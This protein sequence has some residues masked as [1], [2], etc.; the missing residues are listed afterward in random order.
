MAPDRI[1]LQ[2]RREHEM[3][4]EKRLSRSER[5]GPARRPPPEPAGPAISHRIRGLP[6]RWRILSIAILNSAVALVLL[7][8][9]WDGAKALSSAWTALRHVRQSEQ[10]LVAIESDVGRLQ[11]LI[12]RYFTQAT[13]ELLVEI[14]RRRSSLIS[15]LLTAALDSAFADQAYTLT[16]P[17]EQFLAGFDRLRDVRTALQET[18]ENEILGTA[19]EMAGLYSI[20]DGETKGSGELIWPALGKSREAFNAALLAANAY[21]LTVSSKSGEDARRNAETIEQTVPVMLDLAT[22][23]LQKRALAALRDRAAALRRGLDGLASRFD[24]QDQLLKGEIDASSLRMMAAIDQMTAVFRREEDLAQSR[25][26]RALQEAY[27]KVG[28]VAFLFVFFVIVIGIGVARSINEPLRELMVAMHE[29]VRGRYDFEL[30]GRDAADETG[31]MARAVDVFRN[32]AIAKQQAEREL[33]ASKERAEQAL[34]D[35]RET[36]QSL[37]EAE[38]LAALGGLVAGVA[39]EVNNPV[40]ISITVASSLSRRCDSFSKEI[41]TEQLRR[42]RLKDFVAGVRDAADQLVANLQRAGELVQSFKQVAVDRSHAERRVFDLKEATEQILSS[43]RLGLKKRQIAL[44]VDI[45]PGVA[46]DSYPGPY[47]QI[48]TNL[49]INAL[50]HGFIEGQPGTIRVGAR[51]V[52]ADQVELVF[53]D[54]GVGMASDVQRR[55]FDPFF[56]TLRGRGGSGL[57]LHIV[58]NLVT[59]RL[60]GRI[61]LTSAPGVGTSFRIVLPL[62]A[63]TEAEPAGPAAVLGTV[64]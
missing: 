33:V 16:N 26:D 15:K 54:D 60:G 23:D 62:S 48:V 39:H 32:N 31:E 10:Q 6:I 24:H 5:A 29:I 7:F 9:I 41:E 19:R 12:H 20:I 4:G 17:T 30:P 64:A 1:A 18:Y 55:A 27:V 49:F 40:G 46:L 8:L 43:L 2:E 21:Y 51:L 36:Q 50:N 57:G 56:T 25:F 22:G 38:K 52:D 45:A 63:P 3:H 53:Q 37:I 35:L 13:P 14:E 58:Y 59:R 44:V 42:S 61:S 28:V 34:A 47:G 11:S